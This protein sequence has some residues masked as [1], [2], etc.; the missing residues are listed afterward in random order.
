MRITLGIL[1]SIFCIQIFHAQSSNSNLSQI[2]EK[3]EEGIENDDTFNASTILKDC[4]LAASFINDKINKDAASF[5]FLKGK[6]LFKAGEKELAVPELI[7]AIEINQQLKDIDYEQFLNVYSYL[8]NAERKLGNY[9]VASDKIKEGINLSQPHLKDDNIALARAWYTLGMIERKK[10][11]YQESINLA[12]K[13][14]AICKTNPD[15]PPK[16]FSELYISLGTAY[17]LIGKEIQAIQAFE[18][19]L[20]IHQANNLLYEVTGDVTYNLGNAFLSLGAFNKALK[21][22]DRAIKIYEQIDNTRVIPRCYVGQG[23][24][25]RNWGDYDRTLTHYQKALAMMIKNKEPYPPNIATNYMNIGACYRYME[26]YPKARKN[27]LKGLTMYKDFF[28][29]PHSYIGRAL[30]HLGEV[31][32][33]DGNYDLALKYFDEAIRNY[34]QAKNPSH[35]YIANIK[36]S[37]AGTYHKK[38][39][40]NQALLTMNEALEHAHENN[41]KNPIQYNWIA[42]K[43]EIFIQQ[44][45]ELTALSL[46]DSTLQHLN[47]DVKDMS[48]LSDI[49]LY[50]PIINL[51]KTK[52]KAYDAL[53]LKNKSVAD[54]KKSVVQYELATNILF[55]LRE[56]F[57]TENSR[58]FVLEKQFEVIAKTIESLKELYD[59]TDDSQYVERAFQIAE[60]TKSL[61]L[62]E[63]FEK[64]R[65]T[66]LADIDPT[67]LEREQYLRGNL[68]LYEKLHHKQLTKKKPNDS[69]IQEL[70]QKIFDYKNAYFA[71]QDTLNFHL[72][73]F[74]KEIKKVADLSNISQHL[75]NQ[76]F[77]TIEY[78]LT[79]SSLYVFTFI[80]QQFFFDKVGLPS[81][82]KNQLLEYCENLASPT[83]NFEKSKGKFIADILLK[84]AFERFGENNSIEKITIIPDIWLGYLPFET[85]PIPNENAKMLIEKFD[86]SY[87]Y[88]AHLLMAQKGNSF[89][90]ADKPIATFAPQYQSHNQ[91]IVAALS[92]RSGKNLS[93]L[94]GAKKEAELIAQLFGGDAFTG[95]SVT[96]S[97]FRQ[98]AK[99]YKL[100]H[101][102]MHAELD[103]VNPMYSHF[104]FNTQN[105]TLHDGILTAAEL[106]NLQLNADLAV[107]SACNTGFGKIK[108]GEGI[109]SL[110]RAF[111]YAGVPSTVMSLWKVPDD[112]TSKIM[113]SFYQFLKE[114]DTKDSALRRAKLAYLDQTMTPE[115]KHPFYWAGFVAAGDMDKITATS[116]NY[117]K[118][119]IGLLLVI[120]LI[121][122]YFNKSS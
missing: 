29:K 106:H 86:I 70:N 88:A 58:Q 83:S 40:L 52:A 84:K 14:L 65:A 7:K 93:D 74:S 63:A 22:Y 43:G 122:G 89:H 39:E 33:M 61:I 57:R 15:T 90:H 120:G 71:F 8:G 45:Q 53:F 110:S 5:Y 60:K 64:K 96:E 112:A 80:D 20:E 18:K 114:G 66:T 44:D 13:G 50:L 59:K 97:Q 76:N 55:Q 30:A 19:T 3:I 91:Y 117:W 118:W 82:F 116:S 119:G 4:D 108:K 17:K 28:K 42:T 73:S 69:L 115:Q 1:L 49:S 87:A 101:L 67:I 12:S 46:L 51:I 41:S 54:L 35:P 121:F 27:I 95:N 34:S 9:D 113:S 38:G 72:K 81:Q 85:L 62:M 107:L 75:A 105:D 32:R 94:P 98:S 109:M 48:A 99:D 111:R 16:L 68:E 37:K 100:L 21:Y 56:N 79:D 23:I 102:S 103:D 78:F 25:Y 6:A 24:V 92:T 36:A 26:D 47:F 11:N 104:I 2:L 77:A 31:E 10:G